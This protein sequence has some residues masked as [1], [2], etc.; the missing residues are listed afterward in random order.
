MFVQDA[1]ALPQKDTQASAQAD[2][3]APQIAPPQK[4]PQPSPKDM[5]FLDPSLQHDFPDLCLFHNAHDFRNH[6]KRCRSDFEEAAI[7]ELLPKCLRGEALKW[8]NQSN[9][10]DLA[11]CL[12]ALRAGFAQAS[13]ERPPE[14]AP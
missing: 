8:F 9:H 3:P 1:M 5:G 7:L 12:K 13:P 14:A 10:Q 2:L 4:A 6:I 11:V